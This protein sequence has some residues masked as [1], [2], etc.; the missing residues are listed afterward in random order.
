MSNSI[1]ALNGKTLATAAYRTITAIDTVALDHATFV[2]IASEKIL[3]AGAIYVQAGH[4]SASGTLTC[5]PVFYD[6]D[7]AIIALGSDVV[8]GATAQTATVN[9]ASGTGA[10]RNLSKV[11]LEVQPG[12]YKVKLYVTVLTTSTSV[13]LFLGHDDGFTR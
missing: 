3:G 1:R 12:A 4:N 9:N 5:V 7:D 11:E 13:D 6:R 8:L 2:A 10:S